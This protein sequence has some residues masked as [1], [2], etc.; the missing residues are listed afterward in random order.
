LCFE[1]ATSKPLPL[2]R[3]SYVLRDATES[4]RQP[5]YWLITQQHKAYNCSYLNCTKNFISILSGSQSCGTIAPRS[6]GFYSSF[7]SL[8]VSKLCNLLSGQYHPNK[9]KSVL[10]YDKV[11]STDFAATVFDT[12]DANFNIRAASNYLN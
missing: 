1:A 3:I 4:L 12:T 10:T 9:L 2:I 8:L 11:I 6:S 7:S 5:Q